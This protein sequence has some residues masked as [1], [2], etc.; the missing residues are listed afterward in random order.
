M[1]DTKHNEVKSYVVIGGGVAG[2]S[3]ARTL[4]GL[5][6][7]DKVVII[8]PD[9]VFKE[10]RVVE[11]V[12]KGGIEDVRVVVQDEGSWSA[13]HPN[14]THVKDSV[15]G[16]DVGEGKVERKSG[17]PIGYDALCVCTGSCPKRLCAESDLVISLRDTDS[18]KALSSKLENC[19]SVLIV[20]N[21][22]I[23]LDLVASIYGPDVVWAVRHDHI[24]D[25]FFDAEV[26][27]F[28]LEELVSLREC[29]KSNHASDKCLEARKTESSDGG[30][31]KVMGASVGP[32]WVQDLKYNH[33]CKG[34]LKIEFGCEVCTIE[35]VEGRVNVSFSSGANLTVDL[36]VSA[37]GVDPAPYLHW[38]PK[39]KFQRAEDGGLLVD[40]RQETTQAGVFSAGDSCTVNNRDLDVW[41]Q[42]RLWSQAHA[43][44]TYAAHC[45]L[46]VEEDMASDM[47]FEMFSHVTYFLGKR[48]IL[49]GLYNGQGLE[50]VQEDRIRLYSRVSEDTCGKTFVRVLLVDGRVRGAVCI[51]DTGLEETLENLILDGLNVSQ[52]GA[53]LLDPDANID[54]IFD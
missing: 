17:P 32:R 50:S 4:C 31:G 24:G 53:E 25:A 34:S 35:E 23:A 2:V 7:D 37:I 45:M 29:M 15:V 10:A 3:C 5:R 22:G 12:T 36:V 11:R 19:E 21:G 42:M 14:V 26:G 40:S 9:D 46:G 18:V 38:L 33:A 51:G 6:S 44:G 28:M 41:F 39:D 1:D 43:M 13:S 8:S 30:R 49:L 27:N 48:V 54:D 20:G 16:I 47:A 52:F